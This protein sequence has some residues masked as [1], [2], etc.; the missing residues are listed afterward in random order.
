MK[1]YSDMLM[2]ISIFR[3]IYMHKYSIFSLIASFRKLCRLF[4]V[5]QTLFVL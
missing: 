1:Y 2:L 3:L 4:I 5:N